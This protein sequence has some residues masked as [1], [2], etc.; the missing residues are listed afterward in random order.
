MVYEN[1]FKSLANKE[2]I[3]PFLENQILADKWP[4]KY[5]IT[6]D[7]SPYYGLEADGSPDGYFHPSTH[8]LMGERELYLRFH[9]DTRDKMLSEPNSLQRQMTLG[10]GSSIHGILQAQMQM[11]GLCPPENIEVEYIIEEHHVRGRIDWIFQHPSVGDVI[12][13]CKTR[14]GYK[15]DKTTIADMPSWDA[16]LS[17]A[18]YAMGK[19][20]G[21]LLMMES[22]WPYRLRELPHVRND[23]LLQQIFDKFDYVRMCLEANEPPRHCCTYGSPAMTSCDARFSCW[24]KP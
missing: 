24:L 17:L 23:V 18:E 12:V 10:M 4:E 14:T 16:Q 2:L 1:I 13:E 11:I 8:P 15:F 21:V 3:L 5:T 20:E 9:P 19:T 7:S 6:I 22:A